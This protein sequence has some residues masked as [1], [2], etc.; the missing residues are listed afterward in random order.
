GHGRVVHGVRR[1]AGGQGRAVALQQP[2]ELLL[3][4]FRGRGVHGVLPAR[5]TVLDHAGPRLAARAGGPATPRADTLSGNSFF[6]AAVPPGEAGPAGMETGK[7]YPGVA[8]LRRL[9]EFWH[10][11]PDSP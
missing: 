2:G 5:V 7:N 10:N 8:P 6:R 4:V 3:Q 1:A 9:R 11:C